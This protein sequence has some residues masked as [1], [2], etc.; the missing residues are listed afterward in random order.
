MERGDVENAKAAYWNGDFASIYGNEELNCHLGN[1]ELS[2]KN[3]KDAL[4][5]FRK[6]YV[7]HPDVAEV[8]F[9]A[10][11][12]YVGLKDRVEAMAALTKAI[13]LD[14]SNP[15]AYYQRALLHLKNKNTE[16]AMHDLQTASDLGLV[17]AK[18]RLGNL[19]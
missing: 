13:E 6:G 18:K 5:A 1:L 2:K 19:K 15:E 8:W 4:D 9:G 12:A 16:E 14:Q 3:Y 11:M 10:G 7:N 17:E